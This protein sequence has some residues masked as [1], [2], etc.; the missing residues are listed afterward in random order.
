MKHIKTGSVRTFFRVVADTRS[1]Q[2]ATMV[3]QPGQTSGEP[4]NEHPRS[5]QWLFVVSE[6]GR[7]V[8]NKRS[9]AIRTNSL[10]VIE[11]DEVHQIKNTGKQPLVTINFY[12]PPAYTKRGELKNQ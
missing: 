11:R 12:V 4:S 5:E 7:V 6:H 9:T 3:L 1:L 2:A 8:A 10:V